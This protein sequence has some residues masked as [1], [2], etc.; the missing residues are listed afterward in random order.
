MSCL[1]HK[2]GCLDPEPVE[3]GNKSAE[4]PYHHGDE[5]AIV[6]KTGYHLNGNFSTVQCINGEFNKPIP[7]CVLENAGRFLNFDFSDL[8]FNN[9]MNLVFQQKTTFNCSAKT[10]LKRRHLVSTHKQNIC[11]ISIAKDLNLGLVIGGVCGALIIFLIGGG[12]LC[13]WR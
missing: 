1:S 10:K 5:V 3:N 11:I 7:A 8:P 12:F 4:G 9:L 6:C 2:I 13:C